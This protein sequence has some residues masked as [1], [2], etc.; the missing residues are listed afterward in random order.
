MERLSVGSWSFVSSWLARPG[1]VFDP[2]AEQY[3]ERYDGGKIESV[4]LPKFF[5]FAIRVRM[6]CDGFFERF[7]QAFASDAVVSFERL[8]DFCESDVIARRN[9]GAILVRKGY[10]VP[11]IVFADG[12]DRA[13]CFPDSNDFDSC[14]DSLVES[15]EEPIFVVF[16]VSSVGE[17]YDMASRS[18]DDRFCELDGIEEIRTAVTDRFGRN[19]R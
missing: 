13:F 18:V 16:L 5:P 1:N 2:Q 14:F 9:H 12:Y 11:I 10:D 19:A 4:V 8:C 15:V 7:C 3:D 6:R 17:Q